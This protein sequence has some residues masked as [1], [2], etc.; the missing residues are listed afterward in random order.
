MTYPPPLC[1]RCGWPLYGIDHNGLKH[2]PTC[3]PR[4]LLARLLRRRPR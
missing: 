4:G 2:T 3:P 1:T